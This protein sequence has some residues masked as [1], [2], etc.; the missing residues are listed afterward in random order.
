MS[1]PASQDD[2]LISMPSLSILDAAKPSTQVDSPKDS[3]VNEY[4]LPDPSDYVS[5][6]Q[7]HELYLA[8]QLFG[9]GDPKSPDFGKTMTMLQASGKTLPA[10]QGEKA[11]EDLRKMAADIARKSANASPEEFNKT[12][13]QMKEITGK[14]PGKSEP[15]LNPI[16]AALTAWAEAKFPM[17]ASEIGAGVIN[18]AIANA[19]GLDQETQLQT[20]AHLKNLS[21][22]ARMQLQ[23]FDATQARR[24]HS[25]DVLREMADKLEASRDKE[26]AA[27]GTVFSKLSTSYNEAVKA[28]SDPKTLQGIAGQADK[29][30]QSM[31]GSEGTP[32]ADR[33]QG[34]IEQHQKLED[35]KDRAKLIA[36]SKELMSRGDREVKTFGENSEDDDAR[37]RQEIANEFQV[38]I[39]KLP[40][41]RTGQSQTALYAKKRFDRMVKVQDANLANAQ[42]RIALSGARLD[43]ARQHLE[44]DRQNRDMHEESLALSEFNAETRAH[45]TEI[46][47]GKQQAKNAM[48]KAEGELSAAGTDET[49]K[50]TA[51]RHYR[52]AESMFLQLDAQ[53]AA[54]GGQSELAPHGALDK[55]DV[56]QVHLPPVDP[57]H[58]PIGHHTTHHKAAHPP[59]EV[60]FGRFP[61]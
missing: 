22:V 24:M 12:L 33:V 28:G 34:D 29:A 36:A 61:G 14:I 9:G 7:A 8:K 52:E 18:S 47:H 11:T 38:P 21:E 5:S 39:D 55:I 56:S 58:G 25:A 40:H 37:I 3:P 26:V 45:H 32:F 48:A 49:A 50:A 44:L 42:K 46:D 15:H 1:Q 10:W 43:L 53:Q 20:Q 57:S 17:H 60:D 59:K 16:V 27:Y 13:M 41:L 30:Y 2:P 23:N 31:T 35:G 6:W 4:D 51:V 54:T 19:H